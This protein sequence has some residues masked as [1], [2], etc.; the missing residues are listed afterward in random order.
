[1][2]RV[3]C[4]ILMLA[5]LCALVPAGNAETELVE[6]RNDTGRYSIRVPEGTNYQVN[7]SSFHLYPLQS[8][9]PFISVD[10]RTDDYDPI[11]YLH[12]YWPQ[13]MAETFGD[14]LAGVV[15]HDAYEIGG[16]TMPAVSFT[17]RYEGSIINEIR[18]WETRSDGNVE[19]L[20]RF[21]NSDRDTTLAALDG[22]VRY[23]LPNGAAATPVPG[24][25]G[26]SEQFNIVQYKKDNRFSV[27]MPEGWKIITDLDYGDFC[28][29]VYD[30]AS[31][32]RAYFLFMSMAP[33]LKSQAAKNYYTELS[34]YD[35]PT[36]PKFT[37]YAMAPVLED[38]KLETFL[39]VVPETREV[40]GYFYKNYRYLGFGLNPDVFPQMRNANVYRTQGSFACV[41]AVNDAG[42]PVECLVTA[43]VQPGESYT[44]ALGRYDI[45]PRVVQNFTGIT[46]PKGEMD[47]LM[48][49]LSQCL[50]SFAFSP[51]YVKE[52][53]T[54]SE[55][56]K[57][58]LL[59]QGE[60]MQALHDAMVRSWLGY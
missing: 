3:L 26:T 9:L 30:P 58:A 14:D 5:L 51:D 46:A 33:F 8:D 2:K 49:V 34:V 52:S 6:I 55:E 15:R 13:V 47:A 59:A 28:F 48:P 41:R 38:T 36:Y 21:R 23:Y 54:I 27:L 42:Q 10:R 32:D 1:M 45:A 19:Y 57:K 60:Y 25:K 43:I 22:V 17:F 24:G 31:P 44:D 18:L 40:A 16:K 12:N 37:L 50:A 35:Q 53:V 4:L 39:K 20:A 7:G 11:D 29:K 56:V